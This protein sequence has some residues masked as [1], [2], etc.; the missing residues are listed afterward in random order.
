[1]D[2]W[3]AGGTVSELL[4]SM[5]ASAVVALL[6][7]V[8]GAMLADSSPG[9]IVATPPALGSQQMSGDTFERDGLPAREY[10]CC[11]LVYADPDQSQ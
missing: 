6:V 11:A 7:L 1:M 5:A 10:L 9:A 3:A 4:F 2:R 8:G